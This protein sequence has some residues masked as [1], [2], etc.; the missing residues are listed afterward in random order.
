MG[1]GSILIREWWELSQNSSSQLT[2]RS[3]PCKQVFLRQQSQACYVN[4][5]LHDLT[6]PKISIQS[7]LC[8]RAPIWKVPVLRHLPSTF[9]MSSLIPMP[10]GPFWSLQNSLMSFFFNESSSD[11]KHAHPS[12][13]STLY[14][15]QGFIGLHSTAVLWNI[16]SYRS[17]YLQ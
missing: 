5:F 3:Q 2:T 9:G 13:L 8:P 1:T 6:F 14:N 15:L 17:T 10:L 7:S 11:S 4:S 16:I 12:M